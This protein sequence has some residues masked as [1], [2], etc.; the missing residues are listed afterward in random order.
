MGASSNGVENNN[1]IVNNSNINNNNNLNPENPQQQSQNID[2]PNKIPEYEDIM[3][4]PNDQYTCTDC[5]SVP[6]IIDI[7]PKDT[8]AI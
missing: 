7:N 5:R 8:K 3:K 1:H 4:L 2:S 6:E